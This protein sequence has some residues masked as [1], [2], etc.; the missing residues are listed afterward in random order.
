MSP[1]NPEHLTIGQR[2]AVNPRVFG[3][4]RAC[5]ARQIYSLRNLNIAII[6]VY[7]G[8]SIVQEPE[9]S[10]K[11]DVEAT[12]RVYVIVRLWQHSTKGVIVISLVHAHTTLPLC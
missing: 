4:A 10:F 2:D 1:I 9:T 7:A 6:S 11:D 5:V 12:K 3:T 8:F